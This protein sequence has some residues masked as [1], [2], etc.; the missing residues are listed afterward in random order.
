MR[1]GGAQ[2]V[3]ALDA[4]IKNIKDQVMKLQA[5]LLVTLAFFSS[6][7]FAGHHESKPVDP[8]IKQIKAAY[9]LYIELFIASDYEGIADVMQVPLVQKSD[10][11]LVA[12]TKDEVIAMYKDMKSIIQGGYKYSTVD[13]LDIARVIDSI[14][15]VEAFIT[16]YNE[17]D[18]VIGRAQA[19]YFL[20][21]D[22]GPWRFFY[23][24][25]FML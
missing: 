24:Q 20:N 25:F 2:T 15:S 17:Q 11:A 16:R 8:N 18:E 6:A 21:N 4:L 22:E 5:L 19:I 14:Y 13:S 12:D 23:M 9:D 3:V 10:S 7:A 1:E